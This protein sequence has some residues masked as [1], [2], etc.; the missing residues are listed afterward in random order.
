MEELRQGLQR[1][2]VVIVAGAGVSAASAGSPGRP[3]FI[4]SAITHPRTVGSADE[5]EIDSVQPRLQK[6]STPGTV[7]FTSDY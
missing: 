6:A 3:G 7:S 4:D 2:R 1:G 5:E